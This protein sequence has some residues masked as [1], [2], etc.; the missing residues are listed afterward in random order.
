MNAHTQTFSNDL[1]A[2]AAHLAGMLGIDLDY[3]ATSFFRFVA[4]QVKEDSQASVVCGLCKRAVASDE[5]ERQVLN[6]DGTVCID[7]RPGCLVPKV[8]AL[9]GD[10]FFVPGDLLDGFAPAG[11]IAFLPGKF[12]IEPAPFGKRT[13]RPAGIVDQGAIT[14]G[15]Q[16][17]N[18]YV[19]A[20]GR[21]GVHWYR[22]VRHLQHQTGVPLA[23]IAFDNHLLN[24]GPVR[25]IPV[26]LDFNLPYVLHI[27]PIV[28]EPATVT[29]PV[30][31]R[32]KAIATFKA[33]VSPLPFVERLVR[34]IHAAQHLLHRCSVEHPHFVRRFVAQISQSRPLVIVGDAA[35]AALPVPATFVQ[36]IVVNGL[37][38]KQQ[39]IEQVKL[40]ICGIEP[41]L[42]SAYHLASL[43][44]LNVT[45]NY[46]CGNTS[47]S[48]DVVRACPEIRQPAVQMREFPT[49]DM[50]RVILDAVHDLVRRDSRRE[51]TEQ[52]NVVGL[53]DQF[54]HFT[55]KFCCFLAY[56]F[57]K[58]PWNF[59]DQY[60]TPE[61]GYPNEMIIDVVD[62][63]SSSFDVHE[64]IISQS[65]GKQNKGGNSPS[66]L[67]RGVPLPR[68]LWKADSWKILDPI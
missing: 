10:V 67:K 32:L 68:K 64:L 42:V 43:L 41:V 8:P 16:T 22:Y 28:P 52:V 5:G 58:P 40:L 54:N 7:K 46:F 24:G 39:F 3:L 50:S 37:H 60:G 62:S 61:F 63:V 57:F 27:Q 65:W 13:F 34:F 66:P 44:F 19:D 26:Q 47:S 15:E 9:I 48:S 36:S 29:V 23:S 55:V 45:F 1:P 59:V 51:R 18:A 11:T 49:Q 2:P 30:F 20:H 6:C 56:E 35:P 12:A 14:E 17:A 31:D 38:L 21:A 33:W 4:E 25:N 53:N